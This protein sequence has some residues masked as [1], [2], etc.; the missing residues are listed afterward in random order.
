MNF[1]PRDFE[2][3]R[4]QIGDVLI[5]EG[6]GNANEVG[7]SAIWKG[8]IENYYFQVIKLVYFPSCDF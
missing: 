8:E 5:N 7:K 6:S 1:D 2:R 3:Y 4:L